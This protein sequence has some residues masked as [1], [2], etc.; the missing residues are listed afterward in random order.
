MSGAEFK[1]MDL[2]TLDPVKFGLVP[3]EKRE[4]LPFRPLPRLD[5]RTGKELAGSSEIRTDDGQIVKASN[6]LNVGLVLFVADR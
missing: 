3:R 2:G 5:P 6:R 4:P 1:A